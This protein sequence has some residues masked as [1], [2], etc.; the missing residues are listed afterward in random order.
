[1][2]LVLVVVYGGLLLEVEEE[3][4]K[5]LQTKRDHRVEHHLKII[6]DLMQVQDQVVLVDLEDNHLLH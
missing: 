5:L 6:L 3:V 2:L 4:T 1:M